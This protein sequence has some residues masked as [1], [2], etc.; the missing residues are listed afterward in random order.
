MPVP[1]GNLKVFSHSSQLHFIDNVSGDIITSFGGIIEGMIDGKTFSVNVG[2]SLLRFV[3]RIRILSRLFRT[4]RINVLKIAESI[5]LIIY[6][7][8][9]YLY[10][11]QSNTLKKVFRFPLTRYV[12]TQSISVHGKR[13]VIGEYGNIGR[14]KPVGVFISNDAGAKWEFKNIFKKNSVKNILAVKFD[15]YD[16]H[17]WVFTGDSQR[18]SGIYR[19]NKE[20][21]FGKPIG[22]GLDFRGISSFHLPDKVIWLTNNPF[23]KS[24]V[25]IYCRRSEKTTTGAALPGPVWYSAQFKSEA[26]CCTA[27]EDVAGLAG[28]NVFLLHSRNLVEWKVITKFKKD[29][30]NKRLFLYGLGTFPQMNTCNLNIYLNLDAVNEFDGC[31]IE[32]PRNL[33]KLA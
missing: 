14:K 8:D 27:A 21:T 5:L 12:H 31:V 16:E 22:L 19:F 20:F 7:K 4:N 30:F 15:E 32:I 24:H 9:V 13:V 11:L 1:C 25:R 29:R 2:N 33:S 6:M 28:K 3:S 10:D 26:F 17:Y 18:E 23:G